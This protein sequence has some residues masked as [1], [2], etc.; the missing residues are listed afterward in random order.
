MAKKGVPT[1]SKTAKNKWAPI[2]D[3]GF[4][5]QVSNLA[6]LY[7]SRELE[8]RGPEDGLGIRLRRDFYQYAGYTPA[9]V[10]IEPGDFVI[11][12]M[13]GNGAWVKIDPWLR[14]QEKYIHFS[15]SPNFLLSGNTDAIDYSTGGS[16]LFVDVGQGVKWFGYRFDKKASQ[17]LFDTVIKSN[18]RPG[19]LRIVYASYS[20]EIKNLSALSGKSAKLW[21][22][23]LAES[24]VADLSPL[25]KLC[26][27]RWLDLY[28]CKRIKDAAVDAI[29]Q[30]GP[31]R[32]LVFSLM[33]TS[34]SNVSVPLLGTLTSLLSLSLSGTAISEVEPFAQLV[35]LRNLDLMGT[36]VSAEAVNWLRQQLPNCRILWASY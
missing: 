17:T 26:D 6:I 30:A 24:K 10:L 11:P 31:E 32:L 5:Y 21:S 20:P 2:H 15:T 36:N 13:V 22:L 18:A 14:P 33:G 23:S 35:N 34:I 3:L 27:L 8:V 1:K 4:P 16:E 12:G 19:P 7:T 28:Y 9:T 29:V 25:A